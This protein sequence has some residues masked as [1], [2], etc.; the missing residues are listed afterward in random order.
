MCP[1]IIYMIPIEM[2]REDLRDLYYACAHSEM[3]WRERSHNPS[4]DSHHR[5]ADTPEEF[6]A[7]CRAEMKKY[8]TLQKRLELQF[9]ANF[10]GPEEV[11]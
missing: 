7:T 3:M 4:I 10:W 5:Y 9:P 11:I 1:L 2:T 8:R 6:E